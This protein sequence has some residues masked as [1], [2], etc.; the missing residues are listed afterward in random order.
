LTRTFLAATLDANTLTRVGATVQPERLADAVGMASQ[1]NLEDDA[2]HDGRSR[3]DSMK[4]VEVILH[5]RSLDLFARLTT[6]EL[7]E[8][9]AV[10]REETYPPGSI[11]VREGDFGDCMYLVVEGDVRV[12]REGKFVKR[13]KPGEFFGEMAVLDGET[14]SATVTAATPL[15]LLRL[16]KR[17]LLPLMDEQPGIAIAMCQTLSGHLRALINRR[18]G[19]GGGDDGDA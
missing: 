6:Q 17:D 2:I 13:F 11:I 19:R 7:S 8:L 15:R 9:A 3:E 5:L 4:Q 14:R 10:V 18:E 12:T 16:E 1:G